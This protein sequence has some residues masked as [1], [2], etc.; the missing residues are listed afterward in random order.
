MVIGRKLTVRCRLITWPGWRVT[1]GRVG[2]MGV[3]S[4][5]KATPLRQALEQRLPE[6]MIPSAFVYLDALPLWTSTANS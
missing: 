2:K 6:Y 5:S 4:A 1:L 3:G